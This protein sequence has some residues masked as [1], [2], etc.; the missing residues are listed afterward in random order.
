VIGFDTGPGNLLMD[1]WTQRHLGKPYDHNG[2]WA[3]SG[4]PNEAVLQ[5]L[6]GH[7]FFSRPPPRSTG[8]EM[9]NLDWIDGHLSPGL[10]AE[11]VQST[12]LALTAETIARSVRAYCIGAEQ[13]YLCGGGAHNAA[14]RA[15]LASLLPGLSLGTTDELG[16]GSDWVEACAFAWL[17]RQT[18][19]RQP[20]NLPAVTGARGS[21]IL[22]AVHFA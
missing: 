10:R 20:A 22:G 5:R 14:L 21:R 6:L 1:A 19:A 7:E 11:D 17:A 8:R 3:A 13:I 15:H 18:L 12:L 16:I 4:R 2:A 9:F